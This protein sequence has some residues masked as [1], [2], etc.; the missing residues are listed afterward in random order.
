M[1]AKAV[2]FILLGVCVVLLASAK[3]ATAAEEN[4]LK[5]GG[6]YCLTGF[7]SGAEAYVAKGSQLGE[8]WINE[9]GGLT[10]K[11]QKIPVKLVIEDM[12]GTADGAVAAATK[13]A[14]DHKVKFVVGTV[15][16]FM[17]QAAGSVLEPAKI[18]RVLL[19]NCAMPNEYGPKTPYAFLCQDATVEGMRA[20][21][22]YL[23]ERYPNVK[24]VTYIIPDDGSVPYLQKLFT[25]RA[26]ELGL[27]VSGVTKWA[28]TTQDY[29]PVITE[30]LS[31]KPDSLAFANGWP[32]ATGSMLRVA[33]EMGFKGPVFGGNYDDAYQIREIA[34][35]ENSTDFFIHNLD[36]DSPEM[37]PM[38]KEVTKRVKAK[39]GDMNG[40]YI[41]GFFPWYELKQVFEAANTIDPTA[42]KTAWEN[43][44]SIDTL[45][46][47][48]KMGGLKTYG[49][50]HTVCHPCPIVSLTNGEVK[51]V[52]WVDV[53]SP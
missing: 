22:Q 33:R 42:V 30:A 3:P 13:L 43:M 5:I 25:A 1:K 8:E 41:M 4:V 6:L 47:P 49:I 19:Y 18:V 35:K 12:K 11:G 39:Y 40:M 7:G 10:I 48:G 15:V 27:K 23:K 53:Y 31:S 29:T 26:S 2:C 44:K 46:G 36:L 28:M 38:I 45:Y 17:V 34:G 14:F 9:K 52:K 37:T 16:P 20:S 21:L 24:S 50:N 51:W 32:Q